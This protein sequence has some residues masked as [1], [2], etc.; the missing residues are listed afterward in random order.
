VTES[1]VV[2]VDLGSSGA[3]AAAVSADGAVRAWTHEH[4]P[5]AATW[6]AGRGD[7]HA[8]SAGLER[9]LGA[10]SATDLEIAAVAI[11]GQSPTTVPMTGELAVTCRHP[12][13]N[14]LSL[15][16]QHLAQR[17]LI[18][19]ELGR[20]IEPAQIW[21]W[22]LRRLGAGATQ[23][24]W[25]DEPALPGYGEPVMIGTVIGESDGSMAIPAGTPL[26]S[27]YNDAYMSFW[28]GGLGVPGRGH[29]PGGRTG[30]IGVAVAAADRP[31]EMFGIQSIVAGVEIV[32]GPVNGHGE[33]LDWWAR[34]TGRTVAE[35][36]AMAGSVPPGSGGVIVLP[37]HDGERAPR[38]EPRLRGEIHGLGFDAGPAEIGRAVLESAAYG[39]RHIVEGLA[40]AGVSL[41]VM[42]CG[43]SPALSRLWST[44][45]ASVLEVPVE[46][47]ERPEQLSALGCALAA[48]AAV[49]W[50]DG[51]GAESMESWPIPSMTRVE[52]EPND[53]YRDGYASFVEAGDA[54]VAKLLV[55]DDRSS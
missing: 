4:F 10:V 41:D 8:W 12:V 33:L 34:V 22:A 40:D 38:W 54:A 14:G 18:E 52:P 42:S 28:A 30:G 50:W 49:G 11:G 27:A 24:L 21:D 55:A 47:P 9:A 37:Y 3:R 15:R 7:P 25:P 32:G 6:P 39:L 29:D 2:G 51:V 53:A 43:G 46:V 44:I 26:V 45:K 16:E 48:G 17:E 19:G 20:T 13:G 1:V 23:G 5:E 35:I 31:D 36:L